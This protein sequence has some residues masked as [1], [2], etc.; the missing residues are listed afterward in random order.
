MEANPKEKILEQQQGLLAGQHQGSREITR[1]HSRTL[2][3][4]GDTPAKAPTLS[5]ST[6]RGPTASNFGGYSW[7]IQWHLSDA[8]PKGGWIVQKVDMAGEISAA[9][10]SLGT[11]WEEH[12]PYWEAWKVNKGQSVTDYAEGGDPDDDLYQNP[13]YDADTA[14]QT[15]QTGSANFYEGLKLPSS[16][17]VI[18]GHPAGILLTTKSDPGLTGGSG[19]ISHDL[20][21]R[22]DGIDGDGSTELAPV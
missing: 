14:G 11:G 19:A 2:R 13:G 18:P 1:D 10:R 8:S 5:K 17:K 16:F 7:Q 15:E 4:K 3:R 6:L 12:V 9:D 22:W 20:A 21:A